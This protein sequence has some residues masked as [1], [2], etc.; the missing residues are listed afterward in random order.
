MKQHIRCKWTKARLF[1]AFIVEFPFVSCNVNPSLS[2]VVVRGFGRLEV[3]VCG[4]QCLEVKAC[5]AL[6]L[7]GF[8]CLE[9]T[10]FGCRAL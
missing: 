8:I 2:I 7:Q 5:R 3:W 9:P 1:G 10:G 4:S 6:V